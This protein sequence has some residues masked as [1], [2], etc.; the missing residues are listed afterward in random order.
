LEP[1]RIKCGVKSIE[2]RQRPKEREGYNY[3][4]CLPVIAFCHVIEYVKSEHEDLSVD[5]T[6]NYTL[7]SVRIIAFIKDPPIFRVATKDKVEYSILKVKK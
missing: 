4:G 3:K 2:D 7:L 1:F 6:T 5:R